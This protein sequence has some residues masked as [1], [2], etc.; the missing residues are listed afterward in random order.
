MSGWAAVALLAHV[1][2]AAPSYSA[3]SS[4][5]RLVTNLGRFLESFLGDCSSDNPDFDKASCEESAARFRSDAEGKLHRIEIES[6][7]EQLHFAGWDEKRKAFRMHL[8]PFFAERGFALT[9][10]KPTGLSAEGLPTMKNLPIWIKLPPDAE[11]AQFKRQLER[12]GVRLEILFEP[13]KP[14]VL[15]QKGGKGEYRGVETNLAGLRAISERGSVL[16]EQTYP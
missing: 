11:E 3:Q 6:P 12:G 16:A 2:A 13:K 10:G 9:V 14:W 1:A 8:T 5:A 4:S 7:S 15:K